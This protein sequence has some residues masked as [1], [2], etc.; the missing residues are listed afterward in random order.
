VNENLRVFIASGLYDLATP[1]FAAQYT[2]SH[3]WLGDDRANITM[4]T[5][6]SG[7]MIYTHTEELRKLT[8]DAREFYRKSTSSIGN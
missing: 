1:Y 8:D 4:K 3:M 7:H 5:Y 6:E 2:V